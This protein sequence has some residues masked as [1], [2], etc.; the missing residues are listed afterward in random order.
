MTI[1]KEGG[2][3]VLRA[4]GSGKVLGKHSTKAGAERQE[5][6]ILAAKAKAKKKK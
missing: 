2:K 4:K 6:A 1:K 5:R 3:F